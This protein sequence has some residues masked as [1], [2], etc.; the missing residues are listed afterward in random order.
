MFPLCVLLSLPGIPICNGFGS[1]KPLDEL[2]SPGWVMQKCNNEN[3]LW[4][5]NLIQGAGRGGGEWGGLCEP[6]RQASKHAKRGRRINYEL[7]N[8][9]R[10]SLK[11][12]K[13]LSGAE[14]LIV[15]SLWRMSHTESLSSLPHCTGS[16]SSFE[17]N[18]H[19]CEWG[20]RCSKSSLPG[21]LSCCKKIWRGSCVRQ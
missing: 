1:F 16:F 21:L 9:S 8:L 3:C 6:A 12:M 20:L 2:L 15:F 10:R 13:P 5:S 7:D 19:M 17:N 14:S 11:Q 18:Y 4:E